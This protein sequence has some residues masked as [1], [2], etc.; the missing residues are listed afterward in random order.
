M[1]GKTGSVIRLDHQEMKKEILYV[2]YNSLEIDTYL[3]QRQEVRKFPNQD[4][5]E[6]F[7][8]WFRSQIRQ[9]HIDKDSGVSASSE[10]FAL[11][12]GPTSTPIS[13]NSC[14][15]NGVRFVVHSRDERRITQNSGICSLGDKDEEMY[16]GQLEEILEFSYMSFKIVLFRINLNDLDFATLHID[17][18]SID[19]DAPPDIIDVVDEDDDIIDEEDPIPHDLADSDDEDLVNLDIDDGVNVVYSSEEED[20]LLDMSADVARGHGGDGGGDD[21]P[22]PYQVRAPKAQF[23]WQESGQAA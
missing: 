1:I 7:P 2:L 9:R 11:A 15:V 16:Y 20:C 19:V 21:R 12:C 17:G 18:Q 10:L 13:V 22:P 6:E 8:G 5:K 14:V 3:W 23:G 4:M